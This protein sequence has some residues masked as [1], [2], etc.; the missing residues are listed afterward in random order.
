MKQKEASV[1]IRHYIHYK[2]RKTILP[3]IA[4]LVIFNAYV[5]W[6]FLPVQLLQAGFWLSLLVMVYFFVVHYLKKKD[7]TVPKELV[8][9]IIVAF[10]MVVLPGIAGDMKFNGEAML[11]VLSMTLVNFCNLLIFSYH[12]YT[13]DIENGLVSSATQWGLEKTRGTI[14]YVLAGAFICFT[15]WT[16]LIVSPI[17][18]PISIALLIM[19]NILLVI[20]MQEERFAQKGL[21]R[22]WGDFIFLVPGLVWWLFMQ[23]SFF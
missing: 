9:S 15:I 5:A 2:Y 20:Y 7:I 12:D 14:M 13:N 19:L 16:F 22:F 8:V 11:M 21:Y 10:G 1:S 23:R 4:A 18:L 17:K 3:T 6:V